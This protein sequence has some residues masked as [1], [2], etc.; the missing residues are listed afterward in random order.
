MP[1]FDVTVSVEDMVVAPVTPS[2]PPTVAAFVTPSEASVLT[3]VTPSVPP[4]VALPVTDAL[5][6]FE[7]PAPSVPDSVVLPLTEKLVTFAS[8]ARRSTTSM[9]SAEI[10]PVAKKPVA[11]RSTIALGVFSGV[12][13]AFVP[14]GP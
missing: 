11:S 7:A 6:R 3:P 9:L 1:V 4:T 14:A 2:V 10:P 5:A 8:P 13:V 12:P